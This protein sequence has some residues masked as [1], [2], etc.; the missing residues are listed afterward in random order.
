LC[1]QVATLKVF[2][3]GAVWPDSHIRV[4]QT[5]VNNSLLTI[6]LRTSSEVYIIVSSRDRTAKERNGLSLLVPLIVPGVPKG[7][8]NEH[9][10]ATSVSADI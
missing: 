6:V 4:A 3:S 1:Y 5:V 10:V 7:S 8:I 9:R 2:N